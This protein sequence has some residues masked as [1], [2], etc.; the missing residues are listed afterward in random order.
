MCICTTD[1][2]LNVLAAAKIAI[3]SYSASDTRTSLLNYDWSER[4]VDLG[5]TAE[6]PILEDVLERAMLSGSG[7]NR[8]PWC[9]STWTRLGHKDEE[10]TSVHR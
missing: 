3:V 7:R 5:L 1:I 6:S 4:G 10:N 2:F 9:S 8:G